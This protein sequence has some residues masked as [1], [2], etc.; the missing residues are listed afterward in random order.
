MEVDGFMSITLQAG[1]LASPIVI[2]PQA[3]RDMFKWRSSPRRATPRATELY[4]ISADADYSACW[5]AGGDSARTP[6]T[7]QT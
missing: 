4:E 2:E 1:W 7:G 6:R 5:I 3:Y